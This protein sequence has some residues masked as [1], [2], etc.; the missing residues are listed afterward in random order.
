MRSELYLKIKNYAEEKLANGLPSNLYYHDLQH[1]KDVVSAVEEIATGEGLTEDEIETLMIAAWFHDIGY[2][3]QYI[4]HEDESINMTREYLESLQ[5]DE[6]RIKLICNC[7]GATRYRHQPENNLEACL[8]D[9]DRLYMGKI[10][11]ISKGELLR[12]EWAELMDKHH[13]DKEWIEIQY[14]YLKET[15]FY[16]NYADKNYSELKESNIARVIEY[17]EKLLQGENFSYKLRKKTVKRSKKIFK[18]T[19]QLSALGLLISMS[20]TLSIWG[21]E[22][23]SLTIGIISGILI[24]LVLRIFERSYTESIEKSLIFPISLF[25]RTGLMGLLFLISIGLSAVIYTLLISQKP[26]SETYKDKIEFIFSTP[27]NI[28]RFLLIILIISFLINYIKLTSRII[29]QRVLIN[30]MLGKYYKPQA[31]ER[32]FMFIDINSST[33]LAEKMGPEKY[34]HMLNNFF[35]D[36]SPAIAKTKGEI[37]QY[38]G[39]EV[40]VTW[41]MKDGIKKNNCVR[42]FFEIEK[43][44]G[45]LRSEYEKT[46]GMRPDFKAGL[47]GGNVITAE[48]GQLKSDIVY[49]GDVVNTTERILNQCIPLHRKILVS[50]YVTRK[51][52]LLPYYEAEFINTMRLKGRE[53][54]ISLYSIKEI[55]V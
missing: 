43:S 16:T 45:K 19:W 50:E 54:E 51:L 44:L 25:A 3:R 37:Y 14:N 24:G 32:L 41:L 46:F 1:T 10:S 20:A 18:A 42:C 49:H 23:H 55:N 52:N 5:I 17:R 47:H 39:D 35:R 27:E 48:V 12:K 40:V 8:I 29:G 38:V 28:F 34:H 31:E 53:A 4:G 26:T 33:A 2:T 36:I 15:E 30:Y 9:A 6:S 11:F 22:E 7:I 21:F 13:T